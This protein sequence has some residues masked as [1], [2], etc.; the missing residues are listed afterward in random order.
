MGLCLF[1]TDEFAEHKLLMVTVIK[2][3]RILILI[4]FGLKLNLFQE[5]WKAF[6]LSH[7]TR[8]KYVLFS[9]D[10]ACSWLLSKIKVKVNS[11]CRLHSEKFSS[12]CKLSGL[13][14]VD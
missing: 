14:R 8:C 9:F 1:M 5:E 12:S 10:L 7:E 11:I 4:S 2:D 13:V 6:L 3:I